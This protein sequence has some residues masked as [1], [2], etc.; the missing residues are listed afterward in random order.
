MDICNIIPEPSLT[1]RIGWRKIEWMNITAMH[2][3]GGIPGCWSLKEKRGRLK[4]V[5]CG[6]RREFGV[7]VSEIDRQDDWDSFALG[8]VIVSTDFGFNDKVLQS[9]LQWIESRH[10]DLI[11]QQLFMEHR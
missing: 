2:V 11:V 3:V 8:V 9:A 4:P 5:L 1:F 10:P 6:L 7:S